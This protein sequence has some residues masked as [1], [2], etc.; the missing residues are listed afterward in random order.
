MQWK[1]SNVRQGIMDKMTEE[2]H[3]RC[4]PPYTVPFG[5][6]GYNM[7]MSVEAQGKGTDLAVVGIH[8]KPDFH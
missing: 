1:C 5:K 4:M 3:S 2:Q 6:H 8:T 7:G